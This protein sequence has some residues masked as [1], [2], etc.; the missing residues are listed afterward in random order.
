MADR[1]MSRIRQI[2]PSWFLDKELRR[3]TSADAREFYIGLW[4]LA[5]DGGYLTW[6]IERIAA[7]LYPYDGVSR[8]ER[9][10]E[11][12]ADSLATLN[13]EE[14]HL[15][16]YSCGHASVPKMPAHQRI[17]GKRSIGIKEAHGLCRS[18]VRLNRLPIDKSATGAGEPIVAT[19]SHGREQGRE[20]NGTVGVVETPSE[21]STKVPRAVALGKPA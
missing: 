6:D 3:G 17:A 10:V 9:L 1:R 19:D 18:S 21:F 7:E 14:P 12:W 8:R 15:I 11:T 2:K 20:R 16:L 5:D 13:A 4:M